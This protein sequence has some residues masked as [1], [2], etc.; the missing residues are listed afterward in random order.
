MSELVSRLIEL[1]KERRAVILAHN[2]QR[3]EV[4]ETADYCGDSL[5]LAY[6]A[7]EAEADVI[8]FCGVH[9]MAEMAKI[10]CPDTTVLVPDINAGCPMANMITVRELKAMKEKHKTAAVVCYVNS[11]AAVKAESNVCCTSANAD[12]I[13]ASIEPGREIIFVPDK[14]LGSYAAKKAGREK[15][16]ILWNGYCPTHHRILVR[17]IVEKK[18]QHPNAKVIVHPECTEDVIA[19]ADEAASTS[20]IIEYCKKTDAKEIIIGTEINL[21]HRIKRECPDK[22]AIPASI[23][24]DCPNM[25]INTLEKMVWALEDME[26]KIAVDEKTAVLAQKSIEK[27]LAISRAADKK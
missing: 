26:P 11:S 20:G 24:A 12:K 2:Y 17:D 27:M 7:K 6:K 21:I 9:F 22:T 13:I 15:D 1:K 19:L 23:L 18:T 5:G 14:S 16:V 4:Q 3:Q 10:I 8:L 25:A